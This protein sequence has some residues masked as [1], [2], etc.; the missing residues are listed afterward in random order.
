M[1]KLGVQRQHLYSETTVAADDTS[2]AI[3]TPN[4]AVAATFIAKIGAG[5]GTSPTLDLCIQITPDD[6]NYFTV[7]RFAQATGSAVNQYI[8]VALRKVAEAGATG[9]IADTGG[10][11]YG[12]IAISRNI[13]VLANVGGTSPSFA[14]IDVWAIWTLA[15]PNRF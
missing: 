2:D 11:L 9:T 6:T 10:A 7:L 15:A 4:D 12:N 13:K 8:S 5:T 3:I 1:E 14:T